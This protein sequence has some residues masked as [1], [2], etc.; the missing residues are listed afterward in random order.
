MT[1]L[2]Q[3]QAILRKNPPPGVSPAYVDAFFARNEQ[4]MEKVL[5]KLNRRPSV[6]VPTALN[7]WVL[8]QELDKTPDGVIHRVPATAAPHLRRIIQAGW[9]EPVPGKDR[10]WQ[11][12]AKGTAGLAESK[13]QP[14]DAPAVMRADALPAQPTDAETITACNIVSR[15]TGDRRGPLLGD[16]P[17]AEE[18]RRW[19]AWNDRDGEWDFLRHADAE[20]AMTTL[21]NAWEPADVRYWLERGTPQTDALPARSG[22]TALRFA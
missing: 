6:I 9:L 12:S 19:L 18:I 7:I 4:K 21:R 10:A 17:S 16:T 20:E 15:Q 8:Q 22:Q 5:Q 3:I 13:R 2:S 14:H 1:L 11:V